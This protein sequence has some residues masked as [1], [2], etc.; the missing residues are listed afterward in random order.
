MTGRLRGEA[1]ANGRL[2]I[3]QHRGVTGEE[4]SVSKSIL[5][6]VQ[7]VQSGAQAYPRARDHRRAFCAGHVSFNRRR[8][9][10]PA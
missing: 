5:L 3:T 9:S 7:Q 10:G 8:R 6:T 1:K 2:T 4:L